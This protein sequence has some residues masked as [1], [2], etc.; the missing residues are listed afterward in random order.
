MSNPDPVVGETTASARVIVDVPDQGMDAALAR[1]KELERGHADTRVFGGGKTLFHP[2]N[3][4]L[5]TSLI[6]TVLRMT[7]LL[8]RGRRNAMDIGIRENPVSLPRLPNSFDGFTLL[9]ISDLHLDSRPDFPLRLAEVVAPL[10]YDLCVLTGDYRFHT[11]G[12]PRP[13]LGGLSMLRQA[14]KGTAYAVLGNHDGSEMIPDMI[15]M[16]YHLLY[17]TA[18]PVERSGEMFYIVGVDDPHFFQTDDLAMALGSV[19]EGLVRVLLA[20]SPEIY[21]LAEAANVDLLLCGHTHGGQIA[22]PGGRALYANARCPHRINSGNWQYGNLRGYTSVG[23]GSS[24]LDVRF[25]CRPEVTL[26]RLCCPC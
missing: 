12:D 22:L 20:H 6:R 2:E 11:H 18:V 26:H 13:A 19:P 5:S 8:E 14:L 16:G 23:A 15:A 3:S 10:E 21:Q 1:R 4:L 7:G 9:H 24:V 17:N 25:N